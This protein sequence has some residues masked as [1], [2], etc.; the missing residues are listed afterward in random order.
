[1]FRGQKDREPNLVDSPASFKLP[2]SFLFTHYRLADGGSLDS[3]SQN[4]T[5]FAKDGTAL[6][7]VTKTMQQVFP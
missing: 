6:Q 7:H 1:M 2:V 4:P 5:L 3:H